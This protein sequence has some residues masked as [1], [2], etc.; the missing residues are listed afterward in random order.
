MSD[1]RTL[2]SKRLRAALFISADGRCQSCGMELKE[3]WHADHIEPWSKTH[4]T[5]VHEMQALC[6]DCNRRK[7]TMLRPHQERILDIANEIIA[8][9]WGKKLVTASVVPGGGKTKMS[10]LFAG[11]LLA[12]GHVQAIIHVVPRSALRDQV[13]EDYSKISEFNPGDYR[14]IKSTNR[15]PLYSRDEVGVVCSFDQLAANPDL[16]V[17]EAKRRRV[18]L[19]LDEVHFLG[20]EEKASWAKSSVAVAECSKVVLAMS[21]T[22]WRHDESAIPLLEYTEPDHEGKRHVKSDINYELTQ[23][24]GDKSIKPVDFKLRDGDVAWSFDRD[25]VERTLSKAEPINERAALRTFLERSETW[26][27]VIDDAVEHWESWRREV[28]PSRILIIGYDQNHARQL[29]KYITDKHGITCALA[30]SDNDDSHDV[31]KTF[32]R[33]GRPDCLVTVGMAS[34]GFDA[35]DVTHLVYLSNWRSLPNFLQ[36]LARAMRIDFKCSVPPEYQW[37]FAFGPDDRRLRM[38]IQWIRDQV[39]IGVRKRETITPRTGEN[40]PDENAPV[41]T[42]IGAIPGA[43]AFEGLSG[44]VQ[45]DT[46]REVEALLRDCPSA[47]GTPPSKLAEILKWK[48]RHQSK[49]NG[50]HEERRDERPPSERK[51]ALRAEL[52]SL[53]TKRDRR[54]GLSFGA[55]GLEEYKVFGKLNNGTTVEELER[56]LAWVRRLG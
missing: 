49:T 48:S 8:G 13:E 44:R 17:H 31:V 54:L 42:A 11:K 22:I 6:G 2:R 33:A 43:A 5:N 7:G 21:G 34:V 35:S 32:R 28:Y 18:L 41:F 10:M 19:I 29:A 56:R 38:M 9:K 26:S 25:E 4:Q 24:I 53:K 36:A 20:D 3:G 16:Y 14:I 45:D 40:T 50:T 23:A 47:A 37:A 15:A 27:S 55:T 30:I 46:A 52:H 1:P 39:D 12:A 51:G